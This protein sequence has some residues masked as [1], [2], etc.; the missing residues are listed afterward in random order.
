MV[1]NAVGA[2]LCNNLNSV[3]YTITYWRKGNDEVDFVVA[4]GRDIWGIEVKSGRSGKA[5]GLTRFRNRYPDARA[6]L[7][8][9]QGI[10]LAEFFSRDAREWLVS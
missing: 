8:G 10:P 2:H 6:L 3:E 5:A 9:G 4:R 1:E 7:V